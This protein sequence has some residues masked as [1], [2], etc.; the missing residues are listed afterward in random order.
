MDILEFLEVRSMEG[1]A[2][3]GGFKAILMRMI[4]MIL[5]RIY[6]LILKGF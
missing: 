2:E 4:K 6:Y 5:T 3:Q 1:L